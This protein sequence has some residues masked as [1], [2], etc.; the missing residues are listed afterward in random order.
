MIFKS[1]HTSFASWRIIFSRVIENIRDVWGVAEA[2]FLEEVV[3]NLEKR[4]QW[5][6]QAEA[7]SLT[8]LVKAE[9]EHLAEQ[10]KKNYVETFQEVEAVPQESNL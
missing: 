5:M 10:T 6:D 4:R 7:V 8:L 2:D 9:L 1:T 3:K